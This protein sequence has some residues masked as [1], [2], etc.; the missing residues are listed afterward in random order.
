VG[1]N[2]AANSNFAARSENF[3]REVRP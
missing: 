2:V 3:Y 1:K